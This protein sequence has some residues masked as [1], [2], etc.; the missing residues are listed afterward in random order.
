MNGQPQHAAFQRTAVSW[1]VS[2]ATSSRGRS[3]ACHAP[4][5]SVCRPH[6]RKRLPQ[7]R[8]A[9]PL[10]GLPDVSHSRSILT[11]SRDFDYE[12]A[13]WERSSA[14]MAQTS[15][16]ASTCGIEGTNFRPFRL[17][18]P[19]VRLVAGL[20]GSESTSI[21]VRCQRHG[22][23]LMDSEAAKAP[24]PCGAA[25]ASGGQG[26]VH[27]GRCSCGANRRVQT[28]SSFFN[29]FHEPYS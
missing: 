10:A 12:T 11:S 14:A 27:Q 20:S 21:P 2:H 4:S 16:S 24:R 7:G 17:R 18:S 28:V 8:E 13:N 22:L 3:I 29:T 1:L 26:F 5:P 23:E 6:A 19:P 9:H 15:A 25:V